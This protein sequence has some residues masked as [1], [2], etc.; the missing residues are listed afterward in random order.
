MIRIWRQDLRKL[1]VAGGDRYSVIC[2]NLLSS[3]LDEERD[4]LLS[5][6]TPDGILIIAG[7]LK[8]EFPKVRQRYEQA[9]LKLIASRTEKE[10]R[11]GT[12]RRSP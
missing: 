4:R 11:S 1:A 5:R 12:F 2:A 9:G 3:L 10:W 8:S 6:L 7:I